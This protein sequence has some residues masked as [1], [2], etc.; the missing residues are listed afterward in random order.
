MRIV[1]N[2]PNL[3]S[4]RVNLVVRDHVLHGTILAESL[5][6]RDLILDH[7]PQLKENLQQQGVQVGELE[8]N[9]EQGNEQASQQFQS[10]ADR[11]A[12]SFSSIAPPETR[13]E[14]SEPNEAE[15]RIRSAQLQVLDLVA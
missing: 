7:L 9:V 2:P 14:R 15:P 5:A 6:A 4:L 10:D 3:G 1:L 13:S 11:E 8:V 12:P